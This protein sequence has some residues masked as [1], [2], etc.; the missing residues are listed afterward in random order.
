MDWGSIALPPCK[1]TLLPKSW[2]LTW[3]YAFTKGMSNIAKP[4]ITPPLLDRIQGDIKPLIGHLQFQSRFRRPDLTSVIDRFHQRRSRIAPLTTEC[5]PREAF[6]TYCK[7]TVLK[8]S[9]LKPRSILTLLLPTKCCCKNK[10][11]SLDHM[12]VGNLLLHSLNYRDVP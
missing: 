6:C 10:Q 1:D 7:C 3:P 5:R 4:I 8:F 9:S 2:V 12:Q 11:A